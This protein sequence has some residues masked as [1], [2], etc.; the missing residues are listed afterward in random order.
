MTTRKAAA[1]AGLVHAWED[2]PASGGKPIAVKPPN[3]A[4]KP[5]AF[6]FPTPAPA[7]ALYDV[8]TPRFRYWV[9]VEAL[10][11]GAAFWGPR[12]PGGRW[13]VGAKLPVLLDE[14]VDLNAYYD[15]QALNFFHGDGPSGL[16]YSG[17]SPDILCHEMGHAVLDAVK[18]GLWDAAS[19]EVAAFHESFGDMSA[20]L[21]GLQVPTLRA[22]V[23]KE[24]GGHLYRSSRLSRLAE[25]VGAAIRAQHPDAVERDCLRNAVNSF[26]YQDPLSLPSSAPATQLS[27]EAHSFSRV[28]TSAFFEGLGGMLATAAKSPSAPTEQELLGVGGDMGDILLKGIRAAPIVSNFYSQVA[29]AMVREA[30]IKN[31]GY[32]A[33][34][35]SSFVRRGLLSMTSAAALTQLVAS[36]PAGMA[37]MAAPT[38]EPGQPLARISIDGGLYGLGKRALFVFSASQPR[39]MAVSTAAFGGGSHSPTSSDAAAGAF[40][41]DLFR[42]GKVRLDARRASMAGSAASARALTTHKLSAEQ[43]AL[44]LRRRLFDCSHGA[45]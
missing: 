45:V 22:A 31:P 20:I 29:A 14:G 11:R 40:V 37:G 3:A 2:D 44:V 33:A 18:P 4:G 23:L 21:S 17:E 1:K 30:S 19:H 12:V 16:V 27:S 35:K 36:A 13:Q 34:L 39:G 9:A 41:E 38:G 10:R 43:G 32:A 8:G 15:R 7:P 6:Q 5:L 42:R 25:Q 26:S 28:F 24:T